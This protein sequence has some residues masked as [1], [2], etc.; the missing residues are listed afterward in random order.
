MVILVLGLP[1]SGKSYFA[2]RLAQKIHAEYSNSDQ[3]RKE[4]FPDRTYSDS[5]KA[6]VYEALLK[7]MQEAIDKEKD[8]VLDATFYK[9]KIR[10]SFITISKGKIVFIEVWAEENIIQERLKKTR[11]FS[12]ADLKVY[13]LL[14]RQWEPLEEPHLSL[15][16]TNNNIDAMLKKAVNFLKDDKRTNRKAAL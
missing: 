5:E 4:M 13:Q 6:M 15:E 10:E 11:S 1:G 8:V 7:K 2:E 14:K 9:N 16:S 12:E 3:I